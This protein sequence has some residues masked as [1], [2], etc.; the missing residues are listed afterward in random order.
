MLIVENNKLSKYNNELEEEKNLIYN[1]DWIYAIEEIKD[2]EET[3][4]SNEKLILI[5]LKE[6]FVIFN[7]INEEK[8]H[9]EVFQNQK[10]YKDLSF[11]FTKS[12]KEKKYIVCTEREVDLL[13]NGF[14]GILNQ[15]NFSVLKGYY[16]EGIKINKDLIALTSNSLITHGNDSIVFYNV[17]KSQII[18]I[19]EGYSF[20]LS[21]TGL[22]LISYSSENIENNL[23]LCACKKYIKRQKNGILLINL[24]SIEDKNNYKEKENI[25]FYEKK[26]FEVHCFCQIIKE[27]YVIKKNP[28]IKTNYFLAGGLDLKKSGGCVKLFKINKMN[29]K[30]YELEEI[31]N[32]NKTIIIKKYDKILYENKKPLFKSAVSSIVQSKKI[33]ITCWDGSIHLL[34]PYNDVL[35]KDNEKYFFE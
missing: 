31:Q 12:E 21:S 20:I 16:R 26:D 34:M 9:F 23:L 6:K 8:K 28:P 24:L 4:K 29:N 10:R 25:I 2:N 15:K 7:L 19:I 18:R 35:D 33:F 11:V 13:E 32:I 17:T 14:W 3:N 27:D 1:S 30:A 5:C 22:C